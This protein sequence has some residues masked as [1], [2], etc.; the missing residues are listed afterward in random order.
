MAAG[1]LLLPSWMPA[2]DGDGFPIPNA[3]VYFYLNL[4][5]TLAPVYADEALTTPLA[6]PV[7]ANSSGRFPAV[8]ADGDALYSA[9]VEAPYGPAGVPFT[10]DNLSASLGAD[11][12]IA[13]AAEAAADEA[14]Q[15]LAEIQATIQ[16]AQD[17]DGVAA[18][19]GAIAG[20]AAG[21]AAAEAV[22]VDKA[23]TDAGNITTGSDWRSSIETARVPTSE[24]YG[25]PQAAAVAALTA[26]LPFF[27]AVNNTI[28]LTCA[29]GRLDLLCQKIGG[30]PIGDQGRVNITIPAGK[31][32][33]TA[34][35]R[36]SFPFGQRVQIA[37]AAPTVLTYSSIISVV[38]GGTRNHL[39]TIAVADGSSVSVGDTVQITGVTGTGECGVLAGQFPVTA[40]PNANQITIQVRAKAAV[41]GAMTVT[42][43]TIVK[44][45]TVLEFQGSS[46]ITL[47]GTLGDGSSGAQPGG[48]RDIA[49]IGN[50][51][52]AFN[53]LILEQGAVLVTQGRFGV[54]DFGG[55]NIYG[56][57]NSVMYSVF[58]CSSNSGGNGVYFLAGG[59]FQGVSGGFSGNNTYGV[60]GA[61]GTTI[62]VTN[63][64]VSGNLNGVGT[65]AG[66]VAAN[67]LQLHGNTSAGVYGTGGYIDVQ[68]SSFI[69]AGGT[70]GA[71]NRG[72]SRIK[73]DSA[74]FSGHTTDIYSESGG[75][76][77]A[78]GVTA[79]TFEP[80]VNTYGNSGGGV[81]LTSLTSALSG[82]FS[83]VRITATDPNLYL[84]AS[85]NTG[86][87][88][89]G[90][91]G[92]L[93]AI[94][95]SVNRDFYIGYDVAGVPTDVWQFDVSTASVIVNGVQILSTRKTGWTADTGTAKRTANA[96]YSGTAEASY[97][98]ATI[99]TLMNALRDQSQAIKA[100]KDDLISH[101]LIGA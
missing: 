11:V 46:G 39:V 6:N 92:N 20:Q 47:H 7:E 14:A 65:L 38:D 69:S 3:K 51:A 89:N 75:V 62:T 60:Y 1:R 68:G 29:D 88:M 54:S 22:L 10:Y 17:A 12:L 73:L 57:Y 28:A 77:E 97:T 79:T 67:N 34:G 41:L 95:Q 90:T 61:Y 66:V 55:D 23:D 45:N 70:F 15:S 91:L 4:T 87:R 96:T 64:S 72:G 5:T 80:A 44:M 24:K 49:I 58:C 59:V 8:W 52:G 21:Q 25:T 37:G 99:Q 93:R 98:Q 36:V 40:K 43:M 48:F 16:A 9:S 84:T 30:W 101:G 56:I 27:E 18:V 31:Y 63:A 81:N 94:T 74:T 35:Q 2:L 83:S 42:G 19:A 85:A 86:T 78:I 32:T 100:L 82:A 76:N 50:G 26:T 33:F 53:G 71:R 13:G